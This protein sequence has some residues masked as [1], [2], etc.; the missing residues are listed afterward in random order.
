[1][2]FLIYYS[3]HLQNYGSYIEAILRG[4]YKYCI[5]FQVHISTP[6]RF[7]FNIY[8]YKFFV[9]RVHCCL[10]DIYYNVMTLFSKLNILIL[11]FLSKLCSFLFYFILFG[12]APRHWFQWPL[13]QGYFMRLGFEAKSCF[14]YPIFTNRTS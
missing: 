3:L 11:F 2:P 13:G 14:P 1:M 5:G 10:S 12:N 6:P 9:L 7:S 4:F 8:F